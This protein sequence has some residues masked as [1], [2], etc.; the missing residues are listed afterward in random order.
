MG[1]EMLTNADMFFLRFQVGPL[2]RPIRVANNMESKNPIGKPQVSVLQSVLA[3][4]INTIS[5]CRAHPTCT[6]WDYR[7]N[8]YLPLWLRTI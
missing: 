6:P 4:G 8:R 5:Q 2:V 7:V 1:M 3:H